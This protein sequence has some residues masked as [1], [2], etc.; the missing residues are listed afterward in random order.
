M[1]DGVATYYRVTIPGHQYCLLLPPDETQST[2]IGGDLTSGN[3]TDYAK[4]LGKGFVLLMNTNIANRYGTSWTWSGS[5]TSDPKQGYYWSVRDNR[6]RY[7]FQTGV[8]G[9]PAADFRT[10]RLR[11][12]IRYVRDVQ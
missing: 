3:V 1:N 2:D 4:Y 10:N 8:S 11:I 6:N 7:F 12:H 9:T 5:S